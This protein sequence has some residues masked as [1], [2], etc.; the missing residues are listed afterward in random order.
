MA[1]R[2]AA[3]NENAKQ[4]IL[5]NEV[6]FKILLKGAKKY[7]GGKYLNNCLK[8]VRTLSLICIDCLRLNLKI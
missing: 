3:L 2:N 1:L 8:T 5:N 4:Y 6:I 7:I